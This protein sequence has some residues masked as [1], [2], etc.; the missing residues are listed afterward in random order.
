[1]TACAVGRRIVASLFMSV[2]AA[3]L[4]AS[5]CRGGR[6]QGAGAEPRTAEQTVATSGGAHPKAAA[7]EKGNAAAC[8]EAGAAFAKG[9]GVAENLPLA[10]SYLRKACEGDEAKGCLDLGTLQLMNAEVKNLVE[11]IASIRRA[12][13]L[14]HGDACFLLGGIAEGLIQIAGLPPDP[15]LAKAYYRKACDYG[16]ETGCTAAK[17]D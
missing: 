15:K 11:S 16:N 2:T 13:D 8:A 1:M 6:P 10:V 17:R 9:E 4:L 7:C 12:C 14:K 3:T 5:A